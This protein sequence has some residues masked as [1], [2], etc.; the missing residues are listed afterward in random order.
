[1]LSLPPEAVEKK[2]PSTSKDGRGATKSSKGLTSES[3]RGRGRGGGH[4]GIG[5]EAEGN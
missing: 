5:D 3:A 1:M 2:R 4:D